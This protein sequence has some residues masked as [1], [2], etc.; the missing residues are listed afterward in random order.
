MRHR[1]YKTACVH[2]LVALAN[3]YAEGHTETGARRKGGEL[4]GFPKRAHNGAKHSIF[5]RPFGI[6]MAVR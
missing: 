3:I 2:G 1:G 6:Q 4:K 5:A